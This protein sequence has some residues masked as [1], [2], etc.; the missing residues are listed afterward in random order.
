MSTVPYFPFYPADYLADTGHLTTE[1]HGAYL[2]LL[3]T[4]WPRAGRLPNDAKK[5]ARIARVSSRR[6][7]L[8]SED[9]LEFFEVDGD[10]LVN[11]R[12]EREHQKAVSKSEKRSAAGKRGAEAKALKTNE[13]TSAN[14]S[15]MLQHSPEPEP[16][17]PP[18]PPKG[19]RR[20]RVLEYSEEFLAF[21]KPF[22]R[23]EGKQDAA[24][25]FDALSPDDRTAATAAAPRYA[26]LTKGTEKKY[27]KTPA[28][29][30]NGRRW[31]DQ[32]IIDAGPSTSASVPEVELVTWAQRGGPPPEDQAFWPLVPTDLRE[33][34]T[35]LANDMRVT[36]MIHDREELSERPGFMARRM[37]TDL[38]DGPPEAAMDFRLR[39]AKLDS[40]LR[41]EFTQQAENG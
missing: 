18:K 31:E 25:A 34:A 41:L 5:L 32:A 27:I 20:K 14:A 21:Y 3:F 35:M 36:L 16:D 11:P 17:N 23:Q 2:L 6:W 37:A 24:R 33:R 29:W 15:A 1:Q 13:P 9:V 30:L 8:V 12:M 10:E 28:A 4:A 39:L 19:G 38:A 22:P 26:E 7:H 40:A